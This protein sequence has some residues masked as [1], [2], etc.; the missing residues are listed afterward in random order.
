MGL[1]SRSHSRFSQKL[2]ARRLPIPGSRTEDLSSQAG[3][4]ATSFSAE[5]LLSSEVVE[6][7]V[8]SSHERVGVECSAVLA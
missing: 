3:S 8:K 4:G 2:P 6:M 1:S 5:P 7:A